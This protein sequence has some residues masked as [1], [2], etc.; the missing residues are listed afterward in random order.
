ME[1]H[2]FLF[3]TPSEAELYQQKE[4]LFGQEVEDH[5]SLASFD[6]AESGKCLALSR[7]TACIMHLMRVLEFGL[8][9]L[10][11]E[12]G[13]RFERREWENVIN[14]IE[15]AVKLI[16]GPHVGTEWR[17]KQKFYSEAAKDF[18]YFK[19]AWRNH[20]MHARERYDAS[21]AKLIFEHVKSFMHHLATGR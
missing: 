5:F 21:E 15:V 11:N 3:L 4:P 2:L 10:A 6:I 20:A 16:N 12:L 13:V 1:G 7:G 17:E 14:D 9:V 19:N 18:R 8:N